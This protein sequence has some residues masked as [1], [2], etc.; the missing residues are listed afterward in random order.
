MSFKANGTGLLRLAAAAVWLAAVMV[1]AQAFM[2]SL[3]IP[4]VLRARLGDR[5]VVAAYEK[6]V[7]A[8]AEAEKM[9]WA[10][11]P[12]KPDHQG[13]SPLDLAALT[14]QALSAAATNSVRE[15]SRVPVGGGT[16]VR[17]R[18]EAEQVP[19]AAL[20]PLIE[21]AEV[22]IPPMR[23]VAVSIEPDSPKPGKG[24]VGLEF[25]TIIGNNVTQEHDEK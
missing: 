1:L 13:G 16:A 22:A 24:K 7:R 6:K 4:G 11:Y 10:A 21:T 15:V 12:A 20:S 17:F 14:A 2:K 19:L 5:A 18:V 25:E 8:T 9:F 23:L 3:T